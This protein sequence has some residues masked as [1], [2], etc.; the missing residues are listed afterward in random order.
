MHDLGIKKKLKK[1][2]SKKVSAL[3]LENLQI[4]F[5]GL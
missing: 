4:R 5:K 2:N 3:H 1:K